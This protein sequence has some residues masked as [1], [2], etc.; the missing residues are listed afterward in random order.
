MID[1]KLSLMSSPSPAVRLSPRKMMRG[2]VIAA[3]LSARAAGDASVLAA[4]GAGDG[5][6]G[7]VSPPHASNSGA[8]PRNR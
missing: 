8:N 5:S 6:G 3:G 7:P 2:P 1:G 4:G